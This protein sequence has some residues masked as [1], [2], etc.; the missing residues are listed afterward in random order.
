MKEAMEMGTEKVV[1]NKC[2]TTYDDEESIKMVKE[3][4]NTGEGY[5]P[6]PVLSCPGQMEVK[7]GAKSNA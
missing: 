7:K 2:G 4:F 6:C 5:A 3:W 1:C